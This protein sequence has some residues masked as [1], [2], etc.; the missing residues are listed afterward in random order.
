VPNA[1]AVIVGIE[2]YHNSGITGVSFARADATAFKDLLTGPLAVPQA[3]VTLLLDEDAHK[4]NFEDQVKYCVQ[5][6]EEGDRF[7]FFYAGHG[8]WANGSNRLTAWETQP[9]NLGGTTVDVEDIL[10]KPLRAS[11]CKQSAIFIDACATEFK[12]A[13]AA[14]ELISDM[15]PRQFEEFIAKSKY[16]AA[17][18]ACSAK[19]KSYSTSALGHGIWTYHLLRALGGDEPDAVVK[20]KWI[21]GESLRDYLN[22]A[23]PRFIRKNTKIKGRQ[24]PYALIGASGTFSLARIREPT[25]PGNELRLR[26]GFADAYFR[27]V[28][29]RPF[30]SLPG[31]SP[32]K[33]HKVPDRA[34]DSADNW[35]RRLLSEE[36]AEEVQAVYEHA[37]DVLKL[38]SRDVDKQEEAGAGTVDT[39]FFRFSVEAGQ[40]KKNHREA[41]VRREIQLRVSHIDLPDEFDDIF[42]NRVDELV[43]PL[44]GSNGGFAKLVDAVE[45]VAEEIDAEVKDDPT[46]EI[47][48]LR[49]TDGTM[50][51]LKTKRELM[52]VHCAGTDGCMAI[53]EH[54]GG[55]NI[56]RLMGVPPKLIGRA[57]SA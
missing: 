15:H 18:F 1:Y 10:L 38:K 14:R 55:D 30:R 12:E 17:F 47:I 34:S 54:L 57:R 51:V 4:A 50:I 40:S 24:Q 2:K 52:T 53:I 27:G 13:G 28:E 21:A 36:I 49:L 44:P 6:L 32:S 41:L 22:H 19:E 16:T 56:T 23:V 39:E 20:E 3:N 29:T 7:Y 35:A 11:D 37:K 45:Y 48:E 5:G 43:L 46:K 8:L 25:K 31:F 9:V 26:P 42:P 33:G